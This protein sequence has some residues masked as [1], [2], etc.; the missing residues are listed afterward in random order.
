M[1]LFDQ[2]DLDVCRVIVAIKIFDFEM[3]VGAVFEIKRLS[4]RKVL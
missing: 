4:Q 2:F 1:S 3:K